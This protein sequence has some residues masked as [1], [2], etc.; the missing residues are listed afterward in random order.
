[1]FYLNINFF[2]TRWQG[3]LRLSPNRLNGYFTAE[4]GEGGPITWRWLQAKSIFA[5]EAINP[6]DSPCCVYI[7]GITAFC[8]ET[9]RDPTTGQP[10]LTH[11]ERRIFQLSLSQAIR[12]FGQRGKSLLMWK[13]RGKSLDINEEAI[14]S[15]TGAETGQK[16]LSI[17]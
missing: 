16:V 15:Y 17:S 7:L 9:F 3:S 13:I 2:K 10:H 6:V 1:M 14:T 12:L 5:D 4:F 8:S 11:S